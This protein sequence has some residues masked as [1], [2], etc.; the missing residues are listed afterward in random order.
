MSE[1]RE[2]STLY[3]SAEKPQPS[4]ALDEAIRAAARRETKPE[5]SHAPHWFGGIA[6][7]LFAALLVTQLIPVDEQQDA[8]LLKQTNTPAAPKAKRVVPG[9]PELARSVKPA[10]RAKSATLEK[11]E[12]EADSAPSAGAVQMPEVMQLMAIPPLHP[13]LRTII[14][15][16]DAGKTVEARE[17]LELFRKRYPEERIPDG[18][19]KRFE[20]DASGQSR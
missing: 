10:M 15:L 13:E 11:E 16:L 18:I 14:D 5:R 7:S 4:A 1:D 20:I 17:K 19:L 9:K 8:F 12:K 6:A 3:Q 2:L